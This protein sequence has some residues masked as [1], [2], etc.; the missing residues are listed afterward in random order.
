M[1]SS[2]LTCVGSLPSPPTQAPFDQVSVSGAAPSAMPASSCPLSRILAVALAIA[3]GAPAGRARVVAVPDA[4]A[5]GV[6]RHDLDVE[7]R[8][9]ELVGDELRVLRLLA[10]GVG[11]EAEHHL[12]GRVHAQEDRSVRLVSHY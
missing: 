5:V 9:A 2:V 1:S 10:V 12:A 4:E 8:D 7:R 11:G 3:A 6:R